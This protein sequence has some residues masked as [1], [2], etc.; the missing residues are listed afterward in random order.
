VRIEL[1]DVRGAEVNE[2]AR[3][4]VFGVLF[5]LAVLGAAGLMASGLVDGEGP[6]AV[7]EVVGASTAVGF[8][9]IASVLAWRWWG[10]GRTDL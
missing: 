8:G 4:A 2:R 5:T 7:L 1:V 3:R 10:G 6:R 9:A